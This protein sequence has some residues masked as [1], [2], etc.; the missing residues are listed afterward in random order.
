MDSPSYI[1]G[2][3]FHVSGLCPHA[4]VG[5]HDLENTCKLRI[6][7]ARAATDSVDELALLALHRVTTAD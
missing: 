6:M 5:G 4:V 7:A 3:L 2:A 1:P